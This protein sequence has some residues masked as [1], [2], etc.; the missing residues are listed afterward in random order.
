MSTLEVPTTQANIAAWTNG[1]HIC[2]F[3][4]LL[5]LEHLMDVVT[6][7]SGIHNRRAQDNTMFTLMLRASLT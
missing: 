1:R 3:H 5:S 4:E 7:F 6:T 2:D